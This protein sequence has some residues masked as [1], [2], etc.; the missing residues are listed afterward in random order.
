MNRP[1]IYKLLLLV[2][3][4]LSTLKASAQTDGIMDLCKLKQQ[5]MYVLCDTS[6]LDKTHYDTRDFIKEIQAQKIKILHPKDLTGV[7]HD[8]I[9]RLSLGYYYLPHKRNYYSYREYEPLYSDSIPASVLNFP[10][11]QEL[12][13]GTFAPFIPKQLDIKFPKLQIL[14]IWCHSGETTWENFDQSV[15][16]KADSLGYELPYF[17][18]KEIANLP[19]LHT[20]SY[21]HCATNEA[22]HP[23]PDLSHIKNIRIY[24]NFCDEW[25]ANGYLF[26][27]MPITYFFNKKFKVFSEFCQI[28]DIPD[29]MIDS[30]DI[31]H[32]RW[33][34]ERKYSVK[35]K[36]KKGVAN[37]KY[38]IQ[39]ED[40][41]LP[42]GGFVKRYS[43]ERFYNNGVADSVWTFRDN[44]QRIYKQ[45]FINN[46]VI[47]SIKSY[48]YGE[49][50]WVI[51]D[52]ISEE[53]EER[54]RAF[55]VPII[56]TIYN[57][58][59]FANRIEKITDTTGTEI[60]YYK[61][62]KTLYRHKKRQAESDREW[63][64][65]I[66]QAAQSK[67]YYMH[68][69]HVTECY[70][71]N[72]VL[73]GK[74]I[75][76]HDCLSYTIYYNEKG[77]I[78]D[79]EIPEKHNY[80]RNSRGYLENLYSDLDKNKNETNYASTYYSWFRN[81]P[82]YENPF[83]RNNEPSM[84]WEQQKDNRIYQYFF[85][86]GLIDSLKIEVLY[87]NKKYYRLTAYNLNDYPNRTIKREYFNHTTQQ[88]EPYKIAYFR[89]DKR[90]AIWQSASDYYDLR[91]D[92]RDPKESI[93][94]YS[95]SDENNRRVQEFYD[96]NNV[97]YKKKVVERIDGHWDDRY[98]INTKWKDTT[99]YYN[100]RGEQI[101]K[102]QNTGKSVVINGL[103]WATCNV[104][105]PGTFTKNPEDAGM[106]YQWNR[107]VGWSNANPMVNSKG[108]TT[109]ERTMPY[110]KYDYEEG[111]TYYD[112][113]GGDTWKRAKQPCPAGWR[114]PTIN[115][116]QKLFHTTNVIDDWVTFNGVKGRV[117]IDRTNNATLFFPAAGVRGGYKGELAFVGESGS[118][119]STTSDGMYSAEYFNFGSGEG[120]A[121]AKYTDERTRGHSIRCV[122][123]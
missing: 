66:K 69:K 35:G 49:D 7:A 23:I 53:Y 85:S 115:E 76:V 71:K 82:K 92:D 112:C 61:N 43:S 99:Y 46:A 102:I 34:T 40:Y 33:D 95:T 51:K 48:K 59:D 36:L 114:V 21:A 24:N 38:V 89:N 117:F 100:I 97:L 41:L 94:T 111:V 9:Y 8:S 79:I 30:N 122:K 55:D 3:L 118:C 44:K 121:A 73:F 45:F 5:P 18:P 109:W 75:E 17:F 78:R 42:Y 123:E 12:H 19:H 63:I 68:D 93:K 74:Y 108:G 6:Q 29:C 58:Q 90:Y 80:S 83:C 13:I 20:L 96:K 54:F 116:M 11:L 88:Y 119:W 113:T 62:G 84:V 103:T 56:K 107:N 120:N 104:D 110:T 10:N 16:P 91:F 81:R 47:D 39:F 28:K 1:T 64:E 26:E 106:F 70:D 87:K 77:E 37:G 2:C 15:H 101:K 27:V 57:V 65:V 22:M 60:S 14:N 31:K 72:D 52:S 98:W 50:Y 4:L 86:N 105:A 67:Y 32:Y 25:N